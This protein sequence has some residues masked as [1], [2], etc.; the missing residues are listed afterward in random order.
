MGSPV[1]ERSR[2]GVEPFHGRGETFRED[3]LDRVGRRLDRLVDQLLLGLAGS[4]QDVI[5]SR[6]GAGRLADTEPDPAE[7][8]RVQ[9][10]VDGLEAVVPCQSAAELD[11]E[12]P[13]RQVELVVDDDKAYGSS[14]PKRRT[15]AAAA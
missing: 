3:H 13:R 12:P 9:V 10:G 15:S 1:A 5:A 7:V 8:T 4:A 2:S 6:L 11:L 14:M